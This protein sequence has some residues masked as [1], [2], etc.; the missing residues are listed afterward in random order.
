MRSVIKLFLLLLLLSFS[1]VVYANMALPDSY[2]YR[3]SLGVLLVMIITDAIALGLAIKV[4][5][6]ITN[7]V[8]YIASLV[9]VY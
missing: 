9:N 5:G 2:Y 4:L 3:S 1:Q 7:T 8:R 6:I